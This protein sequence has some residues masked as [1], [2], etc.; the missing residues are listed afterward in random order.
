MKQFILT[1]FTAAL[2]TGCASTEIVKSWHEPSSTIQ[3]GENKRVLVLAMVKDE[4][5]RRVIED[6][7]AKD[8]GSNAV[9]SYSMLSDQFLKEAS[10]EKFSQKLKD[11]KFEYV[12][13]M[14]LAD[15][16]KDT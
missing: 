16:E 3:A 11:E 6:G 13:M 9:A 12:L 15:I 1:V 5:S 7:I 8:L 2:L 4:T 10:D 14:R